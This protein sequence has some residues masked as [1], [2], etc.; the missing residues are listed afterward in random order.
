MFDPTKN[1]CIIYIQFAFPLFL[2]SLLNS[3]TT[4]FFVTGFGLSVDIVKCKI[5]SSLTFGLGT[6][7]K[8]ISTME[9]KRFFFLNSGS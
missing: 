7:L 6:F 2:I 9:L 5:S 8:G 1:I 4:C 3:F